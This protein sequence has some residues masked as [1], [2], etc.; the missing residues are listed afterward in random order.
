MIVIVSPHR[1][2]AAFSLGLA[3]RAWLADGHTVQVVNCFTRSDY[4]PYSDA[5]SLH[6]NDRMTYVSALRL[7]EDTAWQ[8]TLNA[9]AKKLLLT[10]LNLKDAPRRLR[11]SADEVCGLTVDPADKALLRIRKALTAIKSDA[12]L[13]PLALGG[14]V[15]HVTARDAAM[16]CLPAGVPCAFYEDLP[17]AARPGAAERIGDDVTALGAAI[18]DGFASAPGDVAAAVSSKRRMAECYDSQIDSDVT[19]QIARF[20]ERYD[21]RERVWGDAAWH[22]SKFAYTGEAA[23]KAS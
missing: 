18:S 1:D 4:A 6:A 11:I 12:L 7:R 23:R 15:D 14:H 3:I 19:E 20:C 16:G 8:R 22:A 17:Y 9:N 10:D 5:A 13:I 2:D 21:G